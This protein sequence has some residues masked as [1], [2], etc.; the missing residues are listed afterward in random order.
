MSTV[1]VVLA[2]MDFIDNIITE[3]HGVYKNE[4]EFLDEAK[5]LNY[6]YDIFVDAYTTIIDDTDVEFEMV[7]QHVKGSTWKLS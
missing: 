7:L 5:Q 6:E 4:K 1:L 2:H 3:V